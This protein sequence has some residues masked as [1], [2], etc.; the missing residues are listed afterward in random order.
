M[1]ELDLRARGISGR[2]VGAVGGGG[3]CHWNNPRAG[4]ASGMAPWAARLYN[5]QL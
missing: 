3:L 1:V 4:R 2:G 5:N